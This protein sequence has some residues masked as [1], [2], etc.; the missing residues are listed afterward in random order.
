MSEPRPFYLVGPTGSGKSSFALRLAEKWGG[1]IVNA[2]AYQVYDGIP[3]ISAAPSTEEKARVP[4]HLYGNVPLTESYSVARYAKEASMVI[5]EIQARGRRAIVVGGNGLYVKSLTHGLSDAPPGDEKLRRAMDSLPMEECVAWLKQ[6]DPEGA[7]AMNLLN[8]R[9]VHRALEI[10]LLSGVPASELKASWK[11]ADPE[12][13]DGL[14]IEWEREELYAR[15]NKRVHAML[16]Q[17][18]LDEIAALPDT[19]SDTASKAIGVREFQA[20]LRGE[21]ALQDAV[22]AVQQASRRY[23]KRQLSWFRRERVFR[24]LQL[25]EAAEAY[26]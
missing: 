1:E 24:C 10:T 2:D 12:G 23:A 4:H 5:E 16:E 25:A 7:A 18:V 13:I 19:L 22:A 11:Q 3:I 17:G 8:P 26:L 6:L 14:F 9:Y 21:L 20:H 15:I